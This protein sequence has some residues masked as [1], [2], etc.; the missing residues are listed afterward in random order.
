MVNQAELPIL[1]LDF[2]GVIC[3]SVVECMHTAREVSGRYEGNDCSNISIE[4][5]DKFKALRP[6]AKIGEDFV[7]IDNIIFEKNIINNEQEFLEYKDKFKDKL[8]NMGDRY[9]SKRKWIQ[10]HD[11]DFWLSLNPLYDG[12]KENI[13]R[14][15]EYFNI[16]IVTT[17]DEYS[18][19]KILEF[20]GILFDKEKIFGRERRSS[21]R[22]VL[23]FLQEKYDTKFFFVEDNFTA[24]LDV[25][26]LKISRVLASWGYVN[27]SIVNSKNIDNIFVL[28]LKK[29]FQFFQSQI[30]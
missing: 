26:D 18:A 15:E 29:F 27:L 28:E 9:Y 11:I 4:Y 10:D 19:F 25:E 20:H 8:P 12:I 17:K 1:A 3:D 24:L 22:D 13:S 30:N 5:A 2:D 16:F 21:K 7:L 6:Y 14:L 23:K